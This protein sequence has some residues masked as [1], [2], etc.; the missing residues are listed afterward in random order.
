MKTRGWL[1]K[2]ALV[3]LSV[4]VTIALLNLAI[5][6]GMYIT[7]NDVMYHY[8]AM[9][10]W[11]VLPNLRGA[12]CPYLTYT[13]IHGFRIVPGE[14][15]D[16]QTYDVMMF[17][18][19]FC[20]G[21]WLSAQDTFAGHLKLGHPDLGI[22]NAAVPGYGTDQELLALERYIPM[23]KPGGTVILFTYINDFDDI[24]D[25]WNEVR[26]KPWFEIG[27]DG[28]VLNRPDS[29]VNSFLWSARVFG[30]LAYAGALA[31]NAEPSIYGDD[32]YAA[33]LYTALV[34]RM[35]AMVKQK[36]GHFV[37]LYASG[38]SARSAQG[39]QW[40]A[41]AQVAVARTGAVF[42]SL[43]ANTTALTAN[44]FIDGDIHWNAAGNLANYNY[45]SPRLENLLHSH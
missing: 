23:L 27:A 44:M 15:T 30:V 28:L 3:I 35:A 14:P 22:A 18:D 10:G 6:F 25:R 17:G 1:G 45:I 36:N 37:V 42:I 8:D 24:R 38:R 2:L 4:V 39:R 11:R 31:F 7:H 12:H 20:F 16:T 26:E 33:K 21:S 43:D 9:L 34:E 29:L 41:V 5:V 32:Q 40:A 19:S 13:D